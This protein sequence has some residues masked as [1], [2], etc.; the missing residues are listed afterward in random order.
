M[1]DTIQLVVLFLY[2][3]RLRIAAARATGSPDWL[4]KRLR[5]WQ[6]NGRATATPAKY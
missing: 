3:C 5:S 4:M 6:G 1:P 2:W